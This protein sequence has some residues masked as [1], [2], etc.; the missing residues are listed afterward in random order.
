MENFVPEQQQQQM[1]NKN[2]IHNMAPVTLLASLNENGP[3]VFFSTTV[4]SY[5]LTYSVQSTEVIIR[6]DESFFFFCSV[7]CY[8]KRTTP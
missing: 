8:D 2:D 5:Q 3:R 7:Y 4:K 6:T 1:L